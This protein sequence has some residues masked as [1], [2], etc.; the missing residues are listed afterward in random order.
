VEL[1]VVRIIQGPYFTRQLLSV[2]FCGYSA[3]QCDQLAE[4]A[5]EYDEQAKRKWPLTDVR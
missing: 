1:Y 5:C 2:T 4:Q 3:T